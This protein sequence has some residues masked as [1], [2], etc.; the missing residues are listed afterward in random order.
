MER[1]AKPFDHLLAA[2]LDQC[3]EAYLGHRGDL[4]ADFKRA[5]KAGQV[6]RGDAQHLALLEL[7]QPG[8][9][10]GAVPRLEQR[11]EPGLDLAAQALDAAGVGEP[12]RREA[13]GQPGG[14]G[15]QLFTQGLRA[16]QER[17]QDAG[18]FR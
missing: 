9:R 6:A 8:E 7:A 12:L 13:F 14:M 5:P 16:A 10:G 3:V 2:K 11:T 17:G 15:Q 18:L 1:P 4:V